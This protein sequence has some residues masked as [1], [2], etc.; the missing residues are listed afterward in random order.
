MKKYILSLL[1][2]LSLGFLF[3][4][5]YLPSPL[6]GT[7]TDNSNKIIFRDDGSFTAT[8]I[9]V[10]DPLTYDGNYLVLDNVLVFTYDGGSNSAEWDLSGAIL[11]LKWNADGITKILTL[12]HTSR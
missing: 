11:N 1:F 5:C 9:G 2:L 6:Y 7:W 4:S 3:V 10:E 8:I 12:Y